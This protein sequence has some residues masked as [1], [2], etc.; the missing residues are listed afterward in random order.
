MR[1]REFIGFLGGAAA[2]LPLAAR[3]QQSERIRRIGVL[4]TLTADDEESSAR[5]AAFLDGLRQLG[6]SD[7][8]NMRMD[9]RRAQG[10]VDQI[11]RNA[12]S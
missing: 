8:R 11:R 10:D 5:S 3:A 7:G 1:R 9:T 4:Q 6:W 2:A 12:A